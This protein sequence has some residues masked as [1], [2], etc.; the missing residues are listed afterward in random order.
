MKNLKCFKVFAIMLVISMIA[1]VTLPLNHTIVA[2]A[3][4]VKISDKNVLLEVGKSK[5]LKITGTKEKVTWT[6][7]KKSVATV[8][9]KGKVTT[10]K[11]GT[12]TITATV[13]KKKYTCEVTVFKAQKISTGD[14]SYVIPNDWT[15]TVMAEQENNAM[16]LF[17]PSSTDM[18]KGFS[19]I[20]LLIANTGTAKPDD[21]TAKAY[22]DS[23]VSKE[24]LSEQLLASTGVETKVSDYKT[25]KYDSKLGTANKVSYGFTIEGIDVTQTIYIFYADNYL[26]QIT[27]SNFG[28]DNSSL[29]LNT[30]SEYI[31][32]SITVSE[33]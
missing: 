16:I 23:V 21:K 22:F 7:S 10:K 15:S 14:V 27:V 12:T 1:T 33:K 19:N 24:L 32:N 2:Q 30:L 9:K 26:F 20:N 25:G 28:D 17:Y 11:E 29:D 18:T 6:S 3:A 5:T 8:D 31:M 4:A 13:N